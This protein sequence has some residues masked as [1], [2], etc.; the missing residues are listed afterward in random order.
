MIKIK[1][2]IIFLIWPPFKNHTYTPL[3]F[4]FQ[5]RFGTRTTLYRFEIWNY[6]LGFPKQ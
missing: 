1:E 6:S 5:T 2:E 3:F 4:F